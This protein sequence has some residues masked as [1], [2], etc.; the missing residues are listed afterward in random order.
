MA[1]VI[2]QPVATLAAA[3]LGGLLVFIL[4]RR[5]DH[6]VRL[7]ERQ[8]DLYDEV[9]REAREL[10]LRREPGRQG[11]ADVTDA[12]RQRVDDFRVRF[13]MFGSPA[14][15]AAYDDHAAAHW[16]WAGAAR[17]LADVYGLLDD[18]RAGVVPP[19]EFESE[20]DVPRW[21]SL[22]RDA[23]ADADKAH[24]R[25]RAVIQE[26]SR[27]VPRLP[28]RKLDRIHPRL[29]RAARRVRRRGATATEIQLD[30]G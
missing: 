21:R 2:P 22:A 29:A 14:V 5:R 24:E 11:G 9:L 15:R 12:D 23:R 18:A 20:R 19:H 1:V 17:G 6:A 28:R 4:S 8:I 10:E 30:S 16:R 26:A 3:A 7:W 27:Q 25:L 13:D